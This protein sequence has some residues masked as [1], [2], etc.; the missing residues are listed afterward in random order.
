[1]V[2]IVIPWGAL[3]S[4]NLRNSR[5]R[6]KY[7]AYKTARDATH[8]LGLGQVKDPPVFPAGSV[9]LVLNFYLPDQRHRDP[10][11]TLKALCDGLEGVV[12]HNDHQIRSL[13]WLVV[14][15]DPENARVEIT[16]RRRVR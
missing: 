10:N 3:A 12:Y 16:A 11:N 4:D 13:S 1:M 14:D 7:A 15:I 6:E 9:E 5:D 2:K 8:M